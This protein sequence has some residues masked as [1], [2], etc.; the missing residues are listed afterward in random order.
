M[1]LFENKPEVTNIVRLE[2]E[3]ETAQVLKRKVG[4]L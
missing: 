3:K 1:N 2:F 4:N